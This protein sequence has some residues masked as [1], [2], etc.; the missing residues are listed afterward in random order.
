[1]LGY[2]VPQCREEED[3]AEAYSQLLKT[4]AEHCRPL[5]GHLYQLSGWEVV[6]GFREAVESGDQAQMRAVLTEETRGMGYMKG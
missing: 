4:I 5:H 6:S 2:Y 3:Q 1:M